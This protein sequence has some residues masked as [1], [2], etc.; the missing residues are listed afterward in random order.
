MMLQSSLRKVRSGREE[1]RGYEK[2][3]VVVARW[4]RKERERN[5]KARVLLKMLVS[6]KV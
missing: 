3:R 1:K 4:G 6:S 5:S 2:R